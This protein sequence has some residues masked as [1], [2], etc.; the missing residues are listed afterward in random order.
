MNSHNFL[1]VRFPF[2]KTNDVPMAYSS[3]YEKENRYLFFSFFF[4]V[5]GSASAAK[6][7]ILYFSSIHNEIIGI[8]NLLRKSTRAV[9]LDTKKEFG[10][11]LLSMECVC[12]C[13][14]W[15]DSRYINTAYVYV[16][17]I[18]N[19]F[20]SYSG[21]DEIPKRVQV[22]NDDK[23]VDCYISLQHGLLGYRFC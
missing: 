19:G 17:D 4:P 1:C 8:L 6:I 9:F 16:H 5:L 18:R 3:T 22:M 21:P 15:Y 12:V 14:S 7:S 11:N 13:V 2:P 23:L 10:L 20:V